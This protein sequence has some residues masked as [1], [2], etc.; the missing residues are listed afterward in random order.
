MKPKVELRSMRH[1]SIFP[2]LIIVCV[3]LMLSFITTHAPVVADGPPV[4]VGFSIS[5]MPGATKQ[6]GGGK[7]ILSGIG[8]PGGSMEWDNTSANNPRVIQLPSTYSPDH[9]NVFSFT[10]RLPSPDG[11]VPGGTLHFKFTEDGKLVDLDGNPLA[12]HV[13]GYQSAILLLEA[14]PAQTCEVLLSVQKEDAPGTEV[15][16]VGIKLIHW[17]KT[18]ECKT[19]SYGDSGAEPLKTWVKAWEDGFDDLYEVEFAAVGNIPAGYEAPNPIVFRGR[20]TAEGHVIEVKNGSEWVEATDHKVTLFLER[21]KHDVTIRKVDNTYPGDPLTGAKLQILMPDPDHPGDWVVHPD[22]SLLDFTLSE[23]VV[24][25][26]PGLYRLKELEAPYGFDIRRDIEF[27]VNDSGEVFI[28]GSKVDVVKMANVAKQRVSVW[29]SVVEKGKPDTELTGTRLLLIHESIAQIEDW[30]VD[31]GYTSKHLLP[32][33]YC[34]SVETPPVGFAKCPSI[35]IKV[36]ERPS[37]NPAILIAEETSDP[38]PDNWTWTEP[39]YED[40]RDMIRLELER[41]VPVKFG[42]IDPE[43]PFS[44]LAG[45]QLNVDLTNGVSYH[46]TSDAYPK[47]F[48]LTPGATGVFS[49]FAAP[50]G[51]ASADPIYFAIEEDGNLWVMDKSYAWFMHPYNVLVMQN[52][53]EGTNLYNVSL[54]A[55]KRGETASLQGAFLSL[56]RYDAGTDTYHHIAGMEWI[57]GEAHHSVRLSPGYYKFD[58][59]Y[60]PMGYQ[61]SEASVFRSGMFRIEEDEHSQP[62]FSLSLVVGHTLEY[63]EQDNFAAYLEFDETETYNVTLGAREFGETA[64]LPGTGLKLQHCVDMWANV[65]LDVPGQMW[66]TGAEHQSFQLSTGTYRLVAI[67]HPEGYEPSQHTTFIDGQFYIGLDEND[68]PRFYVLRKESG[69]EFAQFVRQDDF[70]AYLEYN[71]TETSPTE[72]G[73]TETIIFDPSGGIWTDG[74]STNKEV[75]ANAGEVITILEAPTREGYRFLHWQGSQFQPGDTF[76]VPVGGH[77]FTAAWQKITDPAKPS[78]DSTE[79]GGDSTKP[80]DDSTKPGGDST[81]PGGDST[82]PESVT[83]DSDTIPKVGE[84]LASLRMWIILLG[85]AALLAIVAL[86]MLFAKAD[87]RRNKK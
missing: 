69:E 33:T 42:K 38:D 34:F 74:T 59:L 15:A 19:A 47:E 25:L 83:T 13:D 49:E 5:R 18:Q 73:S 36:Y 14:G 61:R 32:G 46:W 6:I 57:T 9:T 76:T 55:C 26:R 54:G 87:A 10:Q 1:K 51:Y 64:S 22:Y 70:A 16:D 28:D 50:A 80:G 4:D 68:N 2:L 30:I 11:C 3:L 67:E 27:E 48:F 86:R 84:Q 40:D 85:A 37:A 35:H 20:K 60:P 31:T 43:I 45:A 56:K 78:D 65:F 75:K 79:P 41:G 63:V 81:E 77:V 17:A 39:E 24:R 66:W 29:L 71:K 44:Q 53:K 82:E 62:H 72:P 23:W 21:A 12:T 52:H 58:L 7:V 8:V